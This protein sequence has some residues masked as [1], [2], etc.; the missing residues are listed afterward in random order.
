MTPRDIDLV[1]SSFA[2]IAP[3]D[4][5][6]GVRFYERLFEIAPEL[7]PLFRGD[8]EEQGRMFMS[9]LTL[10]VNGLEDL[11]SIEPELRHLAVR[12]V[13]YGVSPKDYQAVGSALIWILEKNLGEEF[14][15]DVRDAWVAVYDTLSGVMARAAYRSG[16][17][18]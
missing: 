16:S 13:G 1:Q 15:P 7:R 8:I 10:A 4:D 5:E 17:A 9:M 2:R 11:D 6:T 3:I 18:D 12:H 14:T